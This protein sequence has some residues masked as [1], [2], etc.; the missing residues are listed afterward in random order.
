[1]ISYE[2]K[3]HPYPSLLPRRDT[4]TIGV[5]PT[6]YRRSAVSLGSDRCRSPATRYP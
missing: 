3:P 1:M 5:R 2:H 6:L 4:P